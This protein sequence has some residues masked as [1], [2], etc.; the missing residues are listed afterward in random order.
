VID[1]GRQV[2]FGPAKDARSYFEGLGFLPRPRQTT[3]DY[4]T[5][6]TDEF[7]REYA[8]G[9]SEKNAPHSPES[10]AEAFRQSRYASPLDDQMAAYKKAL[11]EEDERHKDFRQ[12]VKE[13]KQKG[14][15]RYVGA[16]ARCAS[17]VGPA[18][19]SS[20]CCANP[21]AVAGPF[22]RSHSMGRY[23]L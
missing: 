22:T 15:G 12:A 13:S 14:A 2:Y 5:G 8:S 3:P 9:Y 1:S 23:G 10:L 7:E 21:I 6:C 18:S 11:D 16:G 17:R 20:L 4:V 19:R